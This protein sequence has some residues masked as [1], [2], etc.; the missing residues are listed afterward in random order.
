MSRAGALALTLLCACS[1]KERTEALAHLGA[2]SPQERVAAARTLGQL[3]PRALRLDSEAWAALAHATRD[4]VAAVRRE[5]ALALAHAPRERD[6]SDD[7]LAAL[8][9]DSDEAVRL[10]AAGALGLRCGE[11]AQAYLKLAFAPV[12][13]KDDRPLRAAIARAL[14]SCGVTLQALLAQEETSRRAR[15]T[16]LLE[17]GVGAQRA[18]AAAELGLLGRD[19]DVARLLALLEARDG[20]L[21]AAAAEGLGAAGASQASVKLA[22]LLTEEGAI[23][24]AAA[25]GLRALG[26]AAVRDALPGLLRAIAREGDDARAAAEA[27]A[28][29]GSEA[30]CAAAPEAR[31]AEAATL[32][33]QDCPAGPIAARLG[34]LAM[35]KEAD[36]VPLLSA[37]LV[38]QG[39]APEGNFALSRLASETPSTT[40][41]L[42]AQVA[43][44]LGAEP[45]GP[46]LLAV[47]RRER[48]ALQAE[49][50]RRAAPLREVHPEDAYEAA[51][52]VAQAGE[53]A[54]RQS[55]AQR[56]KF[57]LLMEKLKAHGTS[58]SANTSARERLAALLGTSGPGLEVG[59]YASA[60]QAARALHAPG[61]ERENALLQE[62][63]D[64]LALVAAEQSRQAARAGHAGEAPSQ[65]PGEP[66]PARAALF[67]ADGAA[68]A[69]ACAL[70]A[71][72]GDAESSP[73]RRDFTHDPERRVRLA[74]ANGNKTATPQ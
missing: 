2:I 21:V 26:P 32:L 46:A 20:V 55:A 43:E 22:A 3:A 15:A 73:L 50:A 63:P 17:G 4:P 24:A 60:L 48:I 16:R 56:K 64:L 34:L 14:S 28:T 53:R 68:R 7:E 47:A 36:P 62:D 71:S 72:L 30:R 54:P 6:S 65:R 45:V 61:A 12:P 27:I 23:A 29:L 25:R 42:A 8:L 52:E 37:L 69:E 40:H 39:P 10:S 33:A 31:T 19:E 70:L 18:G 5:A 38:A 13:G 44:H 35:R 1:S 11:K 49:R 58:V 66:G 59:L 67:S 74:C 51:R 57:G 9:R 41:Q